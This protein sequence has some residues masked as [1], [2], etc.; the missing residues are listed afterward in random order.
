MN[1]M[2][3][4]LADGALPLDG[5][6]HFQAA[7]REDEGSRAQRDG[8]RDR[9][10]DLPIAR[11][12]NLVLAS[13]LAVMT[14][15][16]ILMATGLTE[17]YGRQQLFD[18]FVDAK[19]VA[20][21]MVGDAAT[22]RFH[23]RSYLL[24]G[25][26]AERTALDSEATDLSD[27]ISTVSQ[28]TAERGS[29]GP[30]IRRVEAALE[31]YS[32]VAASLPRTATGAARADR[33]LLADLSRN[34]DELVAAIAALQSTT[35]AEAAIVEQVQYEYFY[36]MLGIFALALLLGGLTLIGGL[37]FVSRDVSRHI[38]E[39]DEHMGKL[40]RTDT[41]FETSG[42]ERADEIGS[43]ARAMRVFKGASEDL[44]EMARLKVEQAERD[45]SEQRGREQLIH[46]IADDLEQSVGRI[47]EAVSTAADELEQTAGTMTATA[48][49]ASER[50][51]QVSSSMGEASGGV[52]AAAAASDEF[53]M[54]IGE[55]SRQAAMSAELAREASQSAQNADSTIG[56]LTSS[57]QQV[58]Q[59]VELIQ[60]IAKRTNLLA[61][62]ASIEAARGGEA[63][64]GFAV[65][66][67]EVKELAAQTSRATEEIAQQI[68]T[69]QETTGDSAAALKTVSTQI[70]QLETTA[71]SIASAVDQQSV[72][73]QELA[74][75]IDMAA[76]GT[77]GVN[78]NIAQL[79][80]GATATGAAASQVQ[81]AAS[82]LGT[83]ADLLRDTMREFVGKVR[84]R[85]AA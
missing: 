27:S 31:A 34:G 2:T 72:A 36:A 6:D 29:V 38:Q 5:A 14:L 43:M 61:L 37:R 35:D 85:K 81:S 10:E 25:E 58:G 7:L 63:G 56:N 42:T 68:R 49:E 75:N 54:S 24:T 71:I 83:D 57:A 78:E 66:A 20:T 3:M 67:S 4:S 13:F 23:S 39:I 44:Q 41:D 69:M 18:D 48:E 33:A 16:G 79:R 74:R 46:E 53:A 9:F 26:A 60:S 1:M 73:G 80:D 17:L 64:R 70:Q 55:I 59:I 62:N 52:T 21:E 22:M 8:L 19:Q 51:T 30:A 15:S 12:F 40:V 76:T 11:K 50:A 65:V 77:D 28:L 84:S 32:G 45:I 47:A 82:K